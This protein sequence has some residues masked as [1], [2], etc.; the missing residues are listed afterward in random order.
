MAT[1]E[2]LVRLRKSRRLT[3]QQ[4]S[5]RCDALSPGTVSV[6]MISRWERGLSPI[7][8]DKLCL[9]AK[10]LHCT[11]DSICNDLPST[12][13]RDITAI[14]QALYPLPSDAREIVHYAFTAWPGDVLALIY[15]IGVHISLPPDKRCDISGMAIH[16]YLSSHSTDTIS[17]SAPAP[18]IDY[19]LS[20]HEEISYSSTLI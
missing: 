17:A 5:D 4:L 8:S 13:T 6:R 10:A 2:N 1:A 12:A 9:L 11:V 7:P 18:D 20:A 19:L 3:Q 14:A 16:Q 15:M